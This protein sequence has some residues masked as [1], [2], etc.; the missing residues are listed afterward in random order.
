MPISLLKAAMIL[1]LHQ[2]EVIALMVQGYLEREDV[3]DRICV[4][5]ESVH[6]LIFN[7]TKRAIERDRCKFYRS[8]RS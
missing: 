6:M 3:G 5:E 1:D 8:D 4:N 2:S 7:A